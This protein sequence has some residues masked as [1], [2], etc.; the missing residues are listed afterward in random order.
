MDTNRGEKKSAAPGHLLRVLALCKQVARASPS[1]AAHVA[2]DL[3]VLGDIPYR[4]FGYSKQWHCTKDSEFLSLIN[5][6]LPLPRHHSRQ[7]FR[8]SF[9]LSKKVIFELGTKASPM[10]E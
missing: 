10:R 2:G 8:L 7:G 9:V 1:V 5:S 4:S 6:K 3:N